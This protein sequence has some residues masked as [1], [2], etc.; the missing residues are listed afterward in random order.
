M[1]HPDLHTF[2]VVM[3]TGGFV[4]GSL[5]V[6]ATAVVVVSRAVGAHKRARR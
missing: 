6:V 1:K 2:A 5:W 3:A 4:L